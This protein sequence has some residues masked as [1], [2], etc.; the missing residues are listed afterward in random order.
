MISFN[1][2][3]IFRVTG[4]YGR[5]KFLDYIFFVRFLGIWLE[6]GIELYVLVVGFWVD[7]SWFVDSDGVVWMGFWFRIG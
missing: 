1:Y 2:I 7:F 3:V 4:I 5:W 6:G